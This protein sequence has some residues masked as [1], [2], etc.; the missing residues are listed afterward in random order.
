[1]S[2]DFRHLGILCVDD[3]G[4]LRSLLIDC[5]KALKVGHVH[6]AEDGR[7]AADM[8]RRRGED[9]VLA[10]ANP[11]DIIISNWQMSGGDGL[12]LLKWV[13][14]HEKSPD[15]FA[16]FL[17][18]TAFTDIEHVRE[19]RDNGVD[20]IIAKPFS[21]KTL[22]DKILMLVVRD[23]VFIE[24]PQYFGPDRRWQ[25]SPLPHE[26]RR[27]HTDDHPRVHVMKSAQAADSLS[28]TEMKI[29]RL[30]NPLQDKVG[31]PRVSGETQQKAVEAQVQ[32]AQAVLDS[33]SDTYPQYAEDQ[34]LEL[35]SLRRKMTVANASGQLS[36][37]TSHMLEGIRAITHDLVGQGGTF[38]FPLVTRAAKSLNMLAGKIT[39]LDGRKSELIQTHIKLLQLILSEKRAGNEHPQVWDAIVGLEVAVQKCLE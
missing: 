22:R 5:L 36:E 3:S 1:M 8:L 16:P 27:I 37:E 23:L 30:K 29:Y 7:K 20:D 6:V 26:D 10:Q 39:Q 14:T 2:F 18:F 34:V 28:S 11:V 24:S 19:A 9:P 21:V 31:L 4:F 33:F 35:L 38:G 17:M 32:K 12:S 15:R 13:R 25:K